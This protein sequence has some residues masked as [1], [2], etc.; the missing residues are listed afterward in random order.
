MFVIF[1]VYDRILNLLAKVIVLLGSP[2]LG[3]VTATARG[4][5]K[6]GPVTAPPPVGDG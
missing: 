5:N 6:C 2:F 3:R 1:L 4:A